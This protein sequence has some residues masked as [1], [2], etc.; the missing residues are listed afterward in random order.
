MLW[1]LRQELYFRLH[2]PNKSWFCRYP[3]KS[4]KKL[5]DHSTEYGENKMINLNRNIKHSTNELCIEMMKTLLTLM[6]PLPVSKLKVVNV[7]WI[8]FPAGTIMMTLQILLLLP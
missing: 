7:N 2:C 8:R 1:W 4:N 3:E 5:C 6:E